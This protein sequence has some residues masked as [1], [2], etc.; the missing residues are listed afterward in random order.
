MKTEGMAVKL[1]VL[2]A[3][4]AVRVEYRMTVA[5]EGKGFN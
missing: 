4:G 1:K 2:K 5:T 3:T